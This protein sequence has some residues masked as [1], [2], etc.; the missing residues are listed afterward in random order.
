[1][2]FAPCFHF[3][4]SV[5]QCAVFYKSVYDSHTCHF[6]NRENQ[7]WSSWKWC[8]ETDTRRKH[9]MSTLTSGSN[10][11]VTRP[12]YQIISS[13]SIFCKIKPNNVKLC[14]DELNKVNWNHFI[15]SNYSEP[16]QWADT[17]KVPEEGLLPQW[18]HCESSDLLSQQTDLSRCTLSQKHSPPTLTHHRT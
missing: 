14:K 17:E 9:L 4:W 16:S 12:L 3:H 1:M 15:K 8:S 11:W 18:L 13:K 5:E 7:I 2:I 10:A 6:G